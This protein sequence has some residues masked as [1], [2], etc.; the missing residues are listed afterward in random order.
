MDVRQLTRLIG[1]AAKGALIL[2]GSTAVLA[3]NRSHEQPTRPHMSAACAPNWGFNQTRWSRFPALHGCPGSGY[4]SVSEGY[5][6]HPSQQMLY[7]PQKSLLLPGSQIVSPESGFS[8]V[9]ISVFPNKSP[10]A[11]DATSGEKPAM[12]LPQSAIQQFGPSQSPQVQPIPDTR[13]FPG[14]L[15]PGA[16]STLPPLPAPPLPVPG[17]SSL[18]PNMIIGPNRQLIIRPATASSSTFQA[19]HYP[20]HS[21]P[22][23]SVGSRYGNAWLAQQ[24]PPVQPM[25]FDAQ[26]YGGPYETMVDA[27]GP[28]MANVPV[29]QASQSRVLPNCQVYP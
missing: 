22:T 26:M 13:S 28:G 27:N 2:L 7:T 17:Q 20:A 9:P 6:N 12:R 14:S 16:S 11:G 21:T 24:M 4:D 5:E 8:H 25:P 18:Q 29:S 23:S 10:A 3:G 19:N 15:V 1:F